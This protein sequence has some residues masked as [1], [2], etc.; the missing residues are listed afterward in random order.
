MSQRHLRGLSYTSIRKNSVLNLQHYVISSRATSASAAVSVSDSFIFFLPHDTSISHLLETK[1]VSTVSVLFKCKSK[2]KV[3]ARQGNM[4]W[5]NR[6]TKTS[7][8]KP[9][10]RR[11]LKT[12]LR[13]LAN[14]VGA[15][16]IE[17]RLEAAKVGI[18]SRT[19][20]WTDGWTDG[21][22]WLKSRPLRRLQQFFAVPVEAV[23]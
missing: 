20:R 7:I 22:I 9:T 19:D 8:R 18:S 17:N 5:K 3:C 12:W 1:S 13:I 16:R 14:S 10:R 4:G 2:K 21:E 6:Q 23:R 15:R 11:R